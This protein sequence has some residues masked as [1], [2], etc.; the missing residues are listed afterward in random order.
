MVRAKS[1][2]LGNLKLPLV[3]KSSL[4]GHRCLVRGTD[5]PT[6]RG[7][8]D[9]FAVPPR[10]L[11]AMKPSSVCQLLLICTLLAISGGM[12]LGGV[13]GFSANTT[14]PHP[15]GWG[16]VV[17]EAKPGYFPV[18]AGAGGDAGAGIS[19]RRSRRP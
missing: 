17:L 6:D 14:V 16:T 4:P 12:G 3:G 19:G 5:A 1:F 11:V 9:C 18:A 8:R 13:V 15:I 2:I 10:T 7:V